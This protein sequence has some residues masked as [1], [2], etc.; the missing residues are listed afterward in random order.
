MN[1]AVFQSATLAWQG[2]PPEGERI[3]LGLDG[4]DRVRWTAFIGPLVQCQRHLRASL[5]VNS[6]SSVDCLQ[7]ACSL[8]Y[9][10]N[11]LLFA[12]DLTQSRAGCGC[13]LSDLYSMS[14]RGRRLCRAVAGRRAAPHCKD[15]RCL[16]ASCEV[17]RSPS[18]RPR[19]SVPRPPLA[20]FARAPCCHCPTL[21]RNP[22]CR[23][24]V[25]ASEKQCGSTRWCRR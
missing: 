20:K 21:S 16:I 14:L 9:R 4:G 2:K 6:H 5:W 15:N 22:P 7:S 19:P 23:A 17:P 12:E 8:P 24:A 11:W 1:S 13:E 3:K 25:R 10:H 18:R